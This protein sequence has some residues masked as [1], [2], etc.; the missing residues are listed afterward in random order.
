M[1]R[2]GQ[3]KKLTA[4]DAVV[5]AYENWVSL[6]N[7]VANP[8]DASCRQFLD[9]LAYAGATQKDVAW[10][11]E[12]RAMDRSDLPQWDKTLGDY[13]AKSMGDLN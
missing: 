3:A 8:T 13:A 2:P 6:G 12:H 11:L 1:I 5:V 7:S 9:L 10:L 4:P